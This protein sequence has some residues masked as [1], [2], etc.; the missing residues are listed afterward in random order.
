M[1]SGSNAGTTKSSAILPLASRGCRLETDFIIH[2]DK[3]GSFREQSL[4]DGALF[5]RNMLLIKSI[6]INYK[7]YVVHTQF[8]ITTS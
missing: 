2:L 8:S 3:S 1:S 6:M 7:M 5:S 4:I